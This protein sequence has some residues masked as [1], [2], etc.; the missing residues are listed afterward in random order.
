[1]PGGEL[2]PPGGVW[3]NLVA[4]GA[5]FQRPYATMTSRTAVTKGRIA[6]VQAMVI[7]VT[8]VAPVTI[9]SRPRAASG[10]SPGRI[11]RSPGRIRPKAPRISHSPFLRAL[12]NDPRLAPLVRRLGLPAPKRS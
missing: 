7:R 4:W 2:I 8:T 3:W 6:Q 12:R 1:M 9:T 11:L 10:V 5:S